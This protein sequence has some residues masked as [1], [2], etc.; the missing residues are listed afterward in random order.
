MFY[1]LES[2]QLLDPVNDI[3]L[4]ALHCVYLPR[5]W[6]ALDIFREQWNLHSI[7][8]E[9]DINTHQLYAIGTL[10]MHAHA[11][12]APD[13]FNEVDETVT[14]PESVLTVFDAEN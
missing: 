10:T 13:L 9:N 2:Q 3:H 7:R 11:L 12:I 4:Y 8:T 14:A 5:I 1:F 6:H